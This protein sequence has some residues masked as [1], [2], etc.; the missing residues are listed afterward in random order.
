MNRE[1]ISK[2]TKSSSGSSFSPIAMISAM[3]LEFFTCESVKI[4]W[5]ICLNKEKTKRMNPKPAQEAKIWRILR[6]LVRD[7]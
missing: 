6:G 5:A 3:C 4:S 7:Q 2:F 1:A